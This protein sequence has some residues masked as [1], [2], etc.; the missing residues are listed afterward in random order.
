MGAGASTL[1]D[2]LRAVGYRQLSVL[3]LSAAAL[4]V[5]RQRLGEAA[6]RVD[7]IVGDVTA[8]ELP[9]GGFDVWHDRAAFHFL[10]ELE[11]RAAYVAQA[12]RALKPGG[13]SSS[14][15]LAPTAPSNAV[16]CRW[17]AMH[18]TLCTPS[19]AM[20]SFSYNTPPRRIRPRAVPC[21]ISF[22]ATASSRTETPRGD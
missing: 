17:C 7:W 3:D 11:Q 2:D 6:R 5:T 10:T 1:V 4:E 16:A 19:L 9:P 12:R 18:P 20:P 22:T 14:R 13:T 8:V 15:P 21:T